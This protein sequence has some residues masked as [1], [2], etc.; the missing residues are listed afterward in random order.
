MF[1]DDIILNKSAYEKLTI[2]E[3]KDT[4]K[5]LANLLSAS[6]VHPIYSNKKLYSPEL[7]KTAYDFF[8]HDFLDIPFND[9]MFI[10]DNLYDARFPCGAILVSKK[11]PVILKETF[12]N[13]EFPIL[14][15]MEIPQI[16]K[17]NGI[18]LPF[19]YLGYIFK[20]PKK[21]DKDPEILVGTTFLHK[22]LPPKIKSLFTEQA[23]KAAEAIISTIMLMNTKYFTH[24]CVKRDVKMNARREKNGKNPYL[25]Y[26]VIDLVDKIA[27]VSDGTHAS[28]IPHW[29]RGHIRNLSEDK[30][31]P[32][33]PMMINFKGVIP[34][35]KKYLIE[36]E[37][38]RIE[39][40]VQYH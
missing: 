39:K 2:P 20:R 33:A 40:N 6:R 7:T 34:P 36:P 16:E 32:I 19:S 21:N 31:I 1:H 5:T 23:K 14:F 17:T 9:C 18:Y 22:N 38:E 29:R 4:G 35:A 13:G 15:F 8:N 10:I 37:E 3:F 27:N 24:D 30:K 25:D 28:P 11:S 26:T 12:N